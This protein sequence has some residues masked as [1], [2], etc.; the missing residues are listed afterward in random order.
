MNVIEFNNVWK[1]FRKGEKVNSIREAFPVF[2]SELIKKSNNILKQNEFWAL[3]DVT[4][5]VKRGDILGII[6]NNGAGKSTILKLLCGIMPQNKGEIKIKGRI[7]ALIE[8]TT[9]FHPDLTGKEN[10]YLNGTIMGM[11]K[12]EIDRKFDEIVEFSGIEEFMDTPIKRY[13]SGM[14]ARLGFS[15]AAHIDPDILLVDEVL[16]VGDIDFQTK[17]AHKIRELLNSGVTVIFISHNLVLMQSLCKQIILLRKG[18]IL[19]QGVAAEIIPYYQNIAYKHKEE[20][21]KKHITSSDN[22]IQVSNSDSPIEIKKVFIYNGNQEQKEIF[23]V[24]EAISIRVDYEAKKHIKNPEF[25][26]DIFRAD[27]VLCCSSSAKDDSFMLE[28]INGSGTISIELGRLNLAPG[29]Y[30]M[31]VSTWDKDMIYPYPTK[32]KEVF[33]I[34]TDSSNRDAKVVFLPEIRW[35]KI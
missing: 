34:K 13:S 7:S 19:K 20:E 24:G 2:F 10:I 28:N 26:L 30:V 9:G 16:A 12:K 18:E 6:G 17:C 4:F 15:V 8:I 23:N 35:K 14:T 27:G 25:S 31:I 33:R 32:K 29:I 11:T 1:K 21:L 3:K 5:E 22:K